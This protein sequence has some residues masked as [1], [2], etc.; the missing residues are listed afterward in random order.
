MKTKSL[1]DTNP[2]LKASARYRKALI[3]NVASS[4]AIETGS[5]KLAL[6]SLA[7]LK[8]RKRIKTPQ[9]SAR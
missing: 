2:Y 6:K 7:K 5:M 8:Q 3:L 4:T 1:I 9:G